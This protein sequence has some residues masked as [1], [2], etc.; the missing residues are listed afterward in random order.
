MT[1]DEPTIPQSSVSNFHQNLI[2]DHGDHWRIFISILMFF[3]VLLC[4]LCAGQLTM[5]IRYLRCGNWKNIIVNIK[6]LALYLRDFFKRK[7]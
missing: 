3:Y 5:D 6:R 1:Y 2:F 4:S 7:L